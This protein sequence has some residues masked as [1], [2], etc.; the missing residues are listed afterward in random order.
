LLLKIII[1]G[2]NT[3]VFWFL[4]YNSKKGFLYS[5]LRFSLKLFLKKACRKKNKLYVCRRFLKKAGVQTP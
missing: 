1:A 2:L 3:R 4:G 5:K